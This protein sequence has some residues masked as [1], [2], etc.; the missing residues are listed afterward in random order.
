VFEITTKVTPLL[1]TPPTVITTGPVVAAGTIAVMEFLFQ[2]LTV[3]ITPLKVTLLLPCVWPKLLPAILTCV[4]NAPEFGVRL[5]M[6][7]AAA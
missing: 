6:L 5:L 3:A 2:E 1:A 7:G 4:P